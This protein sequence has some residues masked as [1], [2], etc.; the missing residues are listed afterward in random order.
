[1]IPRFL[2]GVLGYVAALLLITALTARP[3][4][5][6]DFAAY[7]LPGDA[8]YPEGVAYQAATGDYFT[9][10]TTNGA[11]LRG[12]INSPA[13][14]VWIVGG[15]D[16]MTTTRGMKADSQGRLFVAT[17]PQRLMYV[18]D[19]ASKQTLAKLDSGVQPSFINDVALTPDGAA[20]FT[21]S[22]SPM[23]YKVAQTGGQWA[24][25]KIDLAGSPIVYQAGFNLG[26]I[27]A[28]ADGKYLILAQGNNGKLFRYDL[29]AHQA[30]QIDLGTDDVLG[31]D[32][33]LLDGSTLYV[34]RN[35]QKLLVTLA[36]SND[37]TRGTVMSVITHPA[38]SFP[39][40][41]AFIPGHILVTNSQFDKRN[42][43]QPP[44]LP[45][46]LLSLPIPGAAP[47]PGPVGMPVT[48]VP[49]PDPALPLVLFGA[50]LLAGGILLR[51]RR[52][53]VG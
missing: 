1:M 12:N 50:L 45:F 27:A 25:E 53:S 24:L 6:D 35:A 51:R 36:L 9:G 41:M 34:M 21:D 38:F 15:T 31:A 33:I 22:S 2:A 39:T 16:G 10:S 42:A 44:S 49:T 5:A 13:A 30:V 3:A 37:Y 19:T 4:A 26:G 7:T 28:G 32:G 52:P 29:T 8:V 11:I 23:L 46:Q 40:T 48:G 17:G 14:E 18:I 43:G 20:Y 47:A